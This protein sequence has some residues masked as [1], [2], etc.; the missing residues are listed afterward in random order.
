MGRVPAFVVR[1]ES[2]F[3]WIRQEKR[4]RRDTIA[5][6]EADMMYFY[7]QT[8]SVA[9]NA[10][11]DDTNLPPLP[12]NVNGKHENESIE[13]HNE[14]NIDKY[15]AHTKYGKK[16]LIRTMNSVAGTIMKMVTVKITSLQRPRA[17][18]CLW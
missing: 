8:K 11:V 16:E 6:R 17:L 18:L 7:T 10:S 12:I 1:A 5:K 4:K 3:H 9:K 2:V 15:S 13:I 14:C